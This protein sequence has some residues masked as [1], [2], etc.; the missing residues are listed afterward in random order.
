M[1]RPTLSAR[2]AAVLGPARTEMRVHEG[3]PLGRAISGW[4]RGHG[5]VL[6]WARI[7]SAACLAAALSTVPSIARAADPAPD[8]APAASGAAEEASA[9]G[10]SFGPILWSCLGVLFGVGLAAWQIRGMKQRDG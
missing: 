5:P 8:S 3:S 7:G 9:G 10:S 2:V 6:S 1:P 4:S